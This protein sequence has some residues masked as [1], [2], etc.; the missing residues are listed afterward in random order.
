MDK[1]EKMI[2][3]IAKNLKRN[4]IFR[5]YPNSDELKKSIPSDIFE[6]GQRKGWIEAYASCL[7]LLILNKPNEKK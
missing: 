6:L 3:I 2:R 1:H 4:L 7:C 5:D